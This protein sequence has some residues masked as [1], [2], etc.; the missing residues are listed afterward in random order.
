MGGG[1]LKTIFFFLNLY[2]YILFFSPQFSLGIYRFIYLCKQDSFFLSLYLSLT[3]K[4]KKFLWK[5]S[6]AVVYRLKTLCCDDISPANPYMAKKGKKK[7]NYKIVY[8]ELPSLVE[9]YPNLPYC[10]K[11]TYIH[12]HVQQN[13]FASADHKFVQT[14][15]V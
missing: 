14:F 13:S 9:S 6:S 5:C 10:V 12:R 3:Q 7:K 11:G 15:F 1:V 4:I 2:I 8:F